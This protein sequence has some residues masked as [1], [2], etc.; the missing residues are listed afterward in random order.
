MQRIY[1]H[2][3]PVRIWHWINAFGFVTMIITGL[4][5]RYVG[6]IDLFSFRTAVN[7]HNWIG[8]V[9]IANFFIWLLFYL[10]S[11][12]IRVYHPDLSPT[13]HFLASFRQ[14]RFYGYGIFKGE[15][16]PFHV[17]A[18]EKFNAMQAMTYQ[19]IMLMLVP[20]QFY[21]GVLLWDVERFSGMIDKLG[22]VRVVDTAHV[23]IFVFF[24]SYIFVHVYLGSLGHTR[25]AHY[26]AMITGW[27]EVEEHAK[28]GA[29]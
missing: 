29:H 2:P 4:Q 13:R 7:V 11:D 15:P 9:L 3:L 23:L 21:T 27:E 24:L 14:L 19:V 28:P 6:L 8:F 22:G 20:L 5:I 26:K 1:V 17:S 16:N 25:T 18:Y 10:F 12:K